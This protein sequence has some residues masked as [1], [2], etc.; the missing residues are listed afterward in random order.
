MIFEIFIAVRI[1]IV[2]LALTLCM[3]D[4]WLSTSWRSPLPSSFGDHLPDIPGDISLYNQ[5]HDDLSSY[6]LN[7]HL[8]H[9]LYSSSV[10][11]P[12]KTLSVIPFILYSVMYITEIPYV[13]CLPSINL[14]YVHYM[15]DINII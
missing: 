13:L 4:K 15:S 12:S 1:Q 14:C 5:C 8:F 9:V 6:I 7:V 11:I 10:F 2:I 3:S